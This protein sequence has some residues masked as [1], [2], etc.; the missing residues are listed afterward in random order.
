MLADVVGVF[1]SDECLPTWVMADDQTEGL[2]TESRHFS[3]TGRTLFSFFSCLV[4]L[5]FDQSCI[6]NRHG[7]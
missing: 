5:L 3:V 6:L 1:E 2:K 4:H 7:P